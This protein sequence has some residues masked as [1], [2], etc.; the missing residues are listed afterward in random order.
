MK[1]I[2]MLAAAAIFCTAGFAGYA[3]YDRATM[4]DEEKFMLANLEA[5]TSGEPSGGINLNF[6]YSG[7]DGNAIEGY[8]CAEGTTLF[9]LEPDANL[10]GTIYAC[11]TNTSKF[12]LLSKIGY[13]YN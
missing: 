3:A 2:K 13:C 5:L 9:I 6:C 12:R 7:G 10:S 4:T 11:S 1:R 8:K